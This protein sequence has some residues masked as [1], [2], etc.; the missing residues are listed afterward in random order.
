MSCYMSLI[1][2][3]I[4][5]CF[6]FELPRIKINIHLIYA[7]NFVMKNIIVICQSGMIF[8]NNRSNLFFWEENW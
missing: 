3:P 5:I 7:I 1:I 4:S 2:N 8:R 6:F